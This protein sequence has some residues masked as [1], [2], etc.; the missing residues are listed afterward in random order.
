MKN[1]LIVYNIDDNFGDILI[2]HCFKRLIKVVLK[3]LKIEEYKINTM[4]LK[5]IKEELITNSNMIFVAGGAL[6]GVNYLNFFEYIE[7]IVEIADNKNIP[8]YF[9]STGLNNINATTGTDERISALLSKKCIKSMSIRENKDSYK[10]WL[11]DSNIELVKVCDPAVWTKHIYAKRL[12]LRKNSNKKIIG[13]NVARGGLFKDNKKK[14]DFSDE[15]KYLND[16]KNKLDVSSYDYMFYTNGSIPDTNTMKYFAQQYNIPDEKL[17]FIN[18]TSELVETISQFDF[19]VAIRMHSSITSYAL[20]IPSI[21]LIYTDKVQRFYENINRPEFAIPLEQ[22]NADKVLQMINDNIE[23]KDFSYDK[24]Y[25]MTLYEYLFKVLSDIYNLNNTIKKYTF[26]EVKEY[27]EE[28]TVSSEE[29][30][31]DYLVKISSAQNLY[32]DRF[33]EVRKKNKIIKEYKSKLKKQDAT[34][35]RINKNLIVRIYREIKKYIKFFK[36]KV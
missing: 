16:L 26:E 28:E 10:N 4:G 20:E 18:S 17:I 1:I 14:W 15:M 25:L 21:N 29:D 9:S 6:F 23:N 31:F 34:L 12:K 27:L 7:K 35:D 22:W 13:I 2:K 5:N 30:V 33:I 3:N 11:K 8:V 24:E 36:I 19:V 32:L